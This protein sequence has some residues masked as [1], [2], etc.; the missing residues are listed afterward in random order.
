MENNNRASNTRDS[1]IL[2]VSIIIVCR[3]MWK[4]LNRVAPKPATED[5]PNE[6]STPII[7]KKKSGKQNKCLTPRK[8]QP[9]VAGIDLSVIYIFIEINK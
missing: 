1:V 7:P 4:F 5:E 3:L 2:A 9:I 8:L 6:Q